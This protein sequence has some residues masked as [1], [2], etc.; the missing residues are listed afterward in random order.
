VTANHQN[1]DE[2]VRLAQAVADEIIA[3]HEKLFEETIAP[4]LERQHQLEHQL[5]E[6]GSQPSDRD[7]AFKLESELDNV[8]ASNLSPTSTEKSHLIEKV[9][10][11]AAVRPDIWRGAATAG[12]LAALAGVA[13][14]CV[15]GYYRP[16]RRD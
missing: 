12:L 2:A 10:P 5:K 8:K 15:V 3:R 6:M 1:A 13:V 9:V 14:A 16:A 11:G 7:F 4:H